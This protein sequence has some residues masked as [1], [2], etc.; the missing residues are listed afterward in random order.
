MTKI[1]LN[2]KDD[3][4]LLEQLTCNP[5]KKLFKILTERVGDYINFKCPE[6]SEHYFFLKNL[7]FNPPP[8]QMKSM[9]QIYGL[10]QSRTS[11]HSS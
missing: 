2:T 11:R 1:F 3:T 8:E 10:K 9:N 6:E 7:Y 5:E 4:Y